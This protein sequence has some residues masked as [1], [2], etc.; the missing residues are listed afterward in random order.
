MAYIIVENKGGKKCAMCK[1][2]PNEYPSFGEYSS[3]KGACDYK[4]GVPIVSWR[5]NTLQPLQIVCL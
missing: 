4:G 1:I 3:K 2:V 5:A